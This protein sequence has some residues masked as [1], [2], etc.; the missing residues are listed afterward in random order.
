MRFGILG[1]IEVSSGETVLTPSA[2]KQRVLLAVLLVAGN[3]VVSVD[4][5]IEELWG[6]DPPRTALQAVRVYVSQLRQMLAGLA[7]PDGSGPALLTRPPGYVLDLG[8]GLLD[9]SEFERLCEQGRRASQD[10]HLETAADLYRNALSLWRG[11]ALYDVAAGSRLAGAAV[12]LQ[13]QWI[14]AVKRRIDVDLQLN[15]HMDIVAELRS[16]ISAHPYHEGLHA[17]LMIAL[18]RSGRSG[19]ALSVYRSLRRNLT[20]ELGIEP[21][22]RLQQVHQAVLTADYR[23]LEQDDLWTL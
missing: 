23:L 13:E 3:S 21:N 9:T 6:D 1:P 22:H 15:R 14:T 11:P 20:D 2:A 4:A 18:Y 12:H 19:E 17:R 8:D 7:G 5:L 16:L 10:G